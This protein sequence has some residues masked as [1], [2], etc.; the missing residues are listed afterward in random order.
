MPTSILIVYWMY[1]RKYSDEEIYEDRKVVTSRNVLI[2]VLVPPKAIG[3]VIGRQGATIKQLQK[4]SGARLYFQHKTPNDSGDN[5]IMQSPRTLFIQG[6]PECAQQAELMIYQ[7]IANIPENVT[8][9]I[10]VPPSY[11]IGAI[12]GKGGSSIRSISHQSGARVFIE[13]IEDTK[14]TSQDRIIELTGS[15][16]QIDKALE[17]IEEILCYLENKRS[18]DVNIGD[19]MSHQQLKPVKVTDSHN[20]RVL[21]DTPQENVRLTTDQAKDIS[22]YVSA[23]EHPGHFWVQVVGVKAL[24]LEDLHKDITSFVASDEA[25]QSYNVKEIIP[26]DFVAA[27]FDE[28]DL[29][30][31]RAKI[32]GETADGQVDL[33]FIDF[34]DNT[35][36]PKENIFKLRSDFTQYPPQAIECQLADVKPFDGKWS[37]EAIV[38]FE[39]MT[40]CAQWKV[41]SA[42]TIKYEAN[43]QETLM[44]SIRLKDTNKGYEIDIAKE[45]TKLGFAMESSCEEMC[46]SDVVAIDI[47]STEVNN[48]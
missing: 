22:V 14:S 43:S 19:P 45:L 16:E 10:K 48:S 13:R 12:I 15:R 23:V 5:C 44:P 30:Y 25:K 18:R 38:A 17:L 7:I 36:A 39:N 37:E 26:G 29:T 11:T 6:S 3:A 27:K 2:E 34:G 40:Y 8:E 47:N 32:L 21:W 31:Y 28:T 46:A 42:Q 20:D 4:E 33:Y 41:L 9:L 1:K 24:H 35:L